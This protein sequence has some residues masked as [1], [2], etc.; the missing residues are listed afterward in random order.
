MVSIVW[1]FN[2]NISSEYIKKSLA[3]DKQH[4][5]LDIVI[6]SSAS[7][8]IAS[9]I[10]YP[11]EVLRSRL[12]DHAH[13]KDIQVTTAN[14]EPYKGMTDAIKRIWNE[15]GYKGFYRGMGTNLVRVV[16]AAVLTLGSF[17]LCS[18]FLHKIDS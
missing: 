12:Q 9:V 10:A 13:G 8:C 14:Y 2:V 6:A 18:Q 5:V 17:E 3:L 7:K 15:E 16:P 1:I 4:S 11:H